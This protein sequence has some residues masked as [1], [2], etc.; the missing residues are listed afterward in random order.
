M[1][2]NFLVWICHWL[3]YEKTWAAKGTQTMQ[4]ALHTLWTHWQKNK[5]LTIISSKIVLVT[6]SSLMRIQHITYCSN[7]PKDCKRWINSYTLPRGYMPM[8]ISKRKLK[9]WSGT[10]AAAL[11][12]HGRGRF[13]QWKYTVVSENLPFKDQNVN[14]QLKCCFILPIKMRE[15][16][17][18][19]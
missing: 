4:Q 10:V 6:K 5:R 3:H 8:R 17:N 1:R 13:A 16:K 14:I 9:L 15:L 11:I 7:I 19:L 18:L 2:Y 12:A